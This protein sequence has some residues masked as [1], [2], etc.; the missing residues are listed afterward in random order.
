MVGFH[1]LGERETRELR[2]AHRGR[3]FMHGVVMAF[4]TTIPVVN[5]VAPVLNA[6]LMTHVFEK[7]RREAGYPA[8][9]TE[10]QR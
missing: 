9:S 7:I 6:A 1:R 8:L 4:V 3:L 5:L 2:R 10:L